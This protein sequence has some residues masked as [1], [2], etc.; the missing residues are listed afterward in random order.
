MSVPTTAEFDAAF[1]AVGVVPT[2]AWRVDV[3]GSRASVETPWAMPA[4]AVSVKDGP[5]VDLPLP[6][7]SQEGV[8]ALLRHCGMEF[9]PGTWDVSGTTTARSLHMYFER[10]EAALDVTIDSTK[11]SAP[12][13]VPVQ[14]APAILTPV[15]RLSG[16][17]FD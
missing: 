9:G 15:P 7:L 3:R 8:D 11:E 10:R 12:A 17:R 14:D 13:P 6:L 2:T 1:A 5:G 4:T 16:T